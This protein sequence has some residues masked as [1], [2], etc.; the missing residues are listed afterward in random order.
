MECAHR[1]LKELSADY[2]GPYVAAKPKPLWPS[3][4]KN[5]SALRA[6]YTRCGAGLAIL[7]QTS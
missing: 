5:N 1:S 6:C 4:L 7:V 3:H 2:G